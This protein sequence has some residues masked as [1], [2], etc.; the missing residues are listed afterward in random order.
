MSNGRILIVEDDDDISNML[1]IF[2]TGQGYHVD[3]AARGNDAIEYCRK[4]IPDIVVLDIMLPVLSGWE[5]FEAMRTTTRTSH[6]PI[7]F[8]TQ[9][10][11]RS[12]RIKGLELGADDYITKPF[13]IEELKLRVRTA[14]NTYKRHNMT[15]PITGL[16]SSRLIEDQ[17]RNLM[18]AED[19][20]YLQIGINNVDWFGDEYGFLAQAEVMRFAT[21]L[22]IQVVDEFGTLDDFIGHATSN[23][24]V[25]VTRTHN[26]SIVIDRLRQ[27][28]D[29]GILSHY[30]FIDRDRLDIRQSDGNLVPKMKLSI[31]A[32]SDKTQRF[33]DIREITETTAELRR[34]DREH[35]GIGQNYAYLNNSHSETS[36]EKE[37]STGTEEKEKKVYELS[38]SEEYSEFTEIEHLLQKAKNYVL[39]TINLLSSDAINLLDPKNINRPSKENLAQLLDV[40]NQLT[41]FLS[42]VQHSLELALSF[43]EID[44]LTS[45]KIHD[46]K[47]ISELLDLAPENAKPS[48]I[49]EK[50]NGHQH[51][52]KI[53]FENLNELRIKIQ[54][55]QK[56]ESIPIRATIENVAN[57]MNIS[58]QISFSSTEKYFTNIPKLKLEQIFYNILR[59]VSFSDKDVVI[60]ISF[61]ENEKYV[62]VLLKSTE[63]VNLEKSRLY[64]ELME[65]C[66]PKSICLYLSKKIINRYGGTISLDNET[67]VI[68]LP[69]SVKQGRPDTLALKTIISSQ[70]ER[71]EELGIELTSDSLI[72]E[73]SQEKPRT[74]SHITAHLIDPVAEDLLSSIEAFLKTLETLPST[75]YNS[76]QWS[77][78][79]QRL[80]YFRHLTLEL[81]DKYP[82]EKTEFDLEEFLYTVK[83]TI[84]S[85]R[86]YEQSIKI[87]SEVEKPMIKTDNNRLLGILLNLAFN[88]LDAM[89]RD[90][91]LEFVIKERNDKF[92]FIEVKDKGDGIPT[93]Q[94]PKIGNLF[95][96]T[97]GHNRGMGL[98][99]VLKN[100][101]ELDGRIE[102]SSEY[103][104]ET[105]FYV[106]LPKSL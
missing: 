16:P 37:I 54:D 33:S 98:Y 72:N 55:Y 102:V 71:L 52:C 92:F 11:E 34:I 41:E 30:S 49:V 29:E 4:K 75:D 15:D 81:L 67:I 24:F 35:K 74:I 43:I 104:E 90:G 69:A 25:L 79:L 12:D 13:D 45:A 2:F 103:G 84:P 87:R 9:L 10:D 78:I 40:S 51:L 93:H 19:W 59:A 58:G 76:P 57:L 80:K 53:K 85:N 46:M 18:R 94:I 38:L 36:V 64:E 50:L 20:T 3:V 95:F 88:A 48:S 60:D 56:K 22:L 97:K 28:F 73:I 86:I 96:T 7:V 82:V 68:S 70:L 31:G 44:S 32:V 27:R 42:L 23:T 1:R 100:L 66:E 77:K 91:I 63:I 8:L 105:T 106:T 61:N 14:I 89:K 62:L 26:V 65:K 101:V 5:V 47:I 83:E 99:N 6:I 39:T 21:S 17:L